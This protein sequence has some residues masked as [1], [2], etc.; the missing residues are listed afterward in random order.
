MMTQSLP[1]SSFFGASVAK[2]VTGENETVV[3]LKKRKKGGPA[4]PRLNKQPKIVISELNLTRIV[5]GSD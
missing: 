2:S 3:V 5:P 1:E 4:E